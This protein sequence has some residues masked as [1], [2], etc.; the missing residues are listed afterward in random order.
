MKSALLLSALVLA[1]LGAT[2]ALAQSVISAQ[3]GM[4]NYTE[5]QV[6]LNGSEIQVTT[7]Q[8]PQM[9]VQDVLSTKEGRAEVLLNPGSF[10]RLGENSSIRLTSSSITRPGVEVLSGSAVLEIASESKD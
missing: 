4:I 10:L 1:G 7:T 8:F 5:G 2:S 3:S 6:L 9:R